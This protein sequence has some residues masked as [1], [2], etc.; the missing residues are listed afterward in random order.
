MTM[1]DLVGR[2]R[3][4]LDQHLAD[5]LVLV[6]LAVLELPCTHPF[7]DG[8]GRTARLLTLQSL[9][10]FDYHVGC[11]IGLGPSAPSSA[12]A[13]ARETGCRPRY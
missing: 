10:H 5:P 4:T 12:G 3:T 13:V 2:Y 9:Y 6:P 1:T 11:F 8:N 7:A